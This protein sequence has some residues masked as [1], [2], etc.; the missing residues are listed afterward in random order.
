MFGM[1]KTSIGRVES[2]AVNSMSGPA[3]SMTTTIPDTVRL[4]QDPV[5]L[6]NYNRG[7]VYA[8]NNKG[9]RGCSVPPV[10]NVCIHPRV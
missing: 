5:K 6:M 7:Y 9:S 3:T 8:S 2:K 1:K 10:P 4:T